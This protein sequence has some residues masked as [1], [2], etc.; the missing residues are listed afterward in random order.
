MYVFLK[1]LSSFLNSKAAV[2]NVFIP[3]KDTKIT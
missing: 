1:Y 3:K 2:G